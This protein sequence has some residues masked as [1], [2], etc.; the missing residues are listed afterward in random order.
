M[1]EVAGIKDATHH[2]GSIDA[3]VGGGLGRE[4]AVGQLK[5]TVDLAGTPGTPRTSESG[6]SPPSPYASD[7][8]LAGMAAISYQDLAASEPN[9]AGAP[10]R[11]AQHALAHRG[12]GFGR[13]RVFDQ[14]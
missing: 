6:C 3:A 9:L 2:F 5:Y 13:S 10:E 1:S 8:E 11:Y 12:D 14:S 7:A 4:A